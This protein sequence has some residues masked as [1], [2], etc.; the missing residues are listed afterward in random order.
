MQ[1]IR[2]FLDEGRIGDPIAVTS[3]MPCPGHEFWHPSP[4]FY[5][6]TGG[7]SL[8]DMG[9]YHIIAMIYLLGPVKR[10]CGAIK[11]SY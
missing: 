3:F 10:V 5:Y 9:P 11:T 1:T 8:F 7:G 6:K 4:E 2:K